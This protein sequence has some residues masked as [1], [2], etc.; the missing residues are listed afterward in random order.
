MDFGAI[1]FV[2]MRYAHKVRGVNDTL[3]WSTQTLGIGERGAK[4]TLKFGKTLLMVI[5]FFF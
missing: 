3:Q 2:V 5:F 1:S 4:P